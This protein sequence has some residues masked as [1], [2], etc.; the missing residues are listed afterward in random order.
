MAEPVPELTTF[1]SVLRFAI[2]LEAASAAFY[3]SAVPVL[4]A[5]GLS[6]LARELAAQHANRRSLLERT[7]QFKL[8][9][10]VLEP[11]SGLDGRRHR[12]DATPAP[13]D[14]VLGR[15]IDL[16]RTAEQF[17]KESSIVAKALL[18]EAARTFQKLGEENARNAAR[19]RSMSTRG[20]P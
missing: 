6:S 5:D 16:E 2:E 15:S 18:T 3:E 13:R 14:H 7:R 9:E 11:V 12:F 19:L 4:R 1:G 17:Y 8:N 20:G 10:I